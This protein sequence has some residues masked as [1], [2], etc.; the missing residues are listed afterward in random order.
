MTPYVRGPLFYTWLFL[1]TA[2]VFSWWLGSANGAEPH[3]PANVLVTLSILLIAIIKCRFVIRNYMEVRFAP[4]WL[5]W[6]CDAWLI[7]NFGMV[8]SFY[9]LV[10]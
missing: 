9:W 2:T 8:S 7:F 10:L 4:S 6:T 3:R 5:Q 1:V